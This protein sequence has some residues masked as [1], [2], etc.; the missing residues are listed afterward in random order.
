MSQPDLVV[1]S[2]YNASNTQSS[3]NFTSQLANTVIYP[4]RLI[5]TKFIM[6]NWIYPFNANNNWLGIAVNKY[7]IN[8]YTTSVIWMPVIDTSSTW[9]TG[10]DFATYLSTRI[11]TLLNTSASYVVPGLGVGNCSATNSVIVTFDA[12]TGLLTFSGNQNASDGNAYRIQ[13]L[14]LNSN[15]NNDV[16]AF[17]KI[18]FTD[19][20]QQSSPGNVFDKTTFTLTS[21]VAD[22]Q[23]NLT[24]T[25]VIYVA[26]NVLGNATND[27]R[28]KD[29]TITGD[30]TIIATIPV[31]A[32]FNGT[33]VYQDTYGKYID[34]NINTLREL[35]II[36]YDEEYNI[37][38]LSN[39]CYATLEFRLQY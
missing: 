23:L 15:I 28:A 17:Y 8:P 10:S 2:S 36:L 30:E 6:P 1:V 22:S 25:G 27:K 11:S 26:S 7:N 39:G 34:T 16:S 4:K 24:S 32:N 29:G 13:L 38:N 33:I 37:L 12:T 35:S 20:K 3:S 21:I 31:N 18:G 5:L 14:T 9:A 19:V